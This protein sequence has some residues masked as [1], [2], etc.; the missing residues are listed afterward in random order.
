MTRETRDIVYRYGQEGL[1]E[2][3]RRMLE[4]AS[5]AQRAANEIGKG[6][7]D[8][9]ASMKVL[10]QSVREAQ[11]AV[12]DLAQRAGP[13]GAVLTRLGPAGLAAAASVAAMGG[14]LGKAVAEAINGERE[15]IKIEA[16]IRASGGA[17][18]KTAAEVDAL[19]KALAR[20]TMA[21]EEETKRA[22]TQ[23]LAFGRVAGE[24]FDRT[25]K[26][27]QDM[28]AA[29]FG[30]LSSNAVALGRALESPR[31]GLS[32]LSRLG[33][34]LTETQRDQI[35]VMAEMGREMEAQAMLLDIIA[36]KMGGTGAAERNTVAGAWHALS[37]ATEDYF[38]NLGEHLGVL[39]VLQA[40]LEGLT[41]AI[42]AQAAAMD[43][44]Y[45][46]LDDIDRRLNSVRM[47]GNTPQSL[48]A[49]RAEILDSLAA[50]EQ[51]RLDRS[52][53]T[54][55]TKLEEAYAGSIKATTTARLE[56]IAVIL[57]NNEK[58]L[59]AAEDR[60]QKIA[61]QR[62]EANRQLRLEHTRAYADLVD[63]IQD[64][65]YKA[66]DD[67]EGTIAK[68]LLSVGPAEQV[69]EWVAEHERA[70]DR[71]KSIYDE[72]SR[73][74]FDAYRDGWRDL[75]SGNIRSFED[76]A[77][78][79]KNIGIDLAANLIA[80]KTFGSVLGTIGGGAAGGA[81]GGG[82]LSGLLG[83]GAGAAGGAAAA[84]TAAG[85]AALYPSFVYGSAGAGG[86][87][88][89][90]LAA[91]L[92][93]PWTAA[94]VASIAAI[95]VLPGLIGPRP[96]DKI[97]GV[98]LDLIA[99]T[100]REGDLGP[101]KDSP[102]NRAQ[103]NALED[104]LVKLRETL[105]AFG[106]SPEARNVLIEV[107]SGNSLA[108][109]RAAV[110]GSG[111]Q[112]F[113]TAEEAFAFL[114]QRLID[115]LEVVPAR[116]QDVVDGFDPG[117]VEAFVS[118][119][120]RFADFETTLAGVRDEILQLTDPQAWDVKRIEDWYTKIREEALALG[121]DM[122]EIDRLRG[123]RLEMVSAQ[124]GAAAPQTP[125]AGPTAN[126]QQ[127]ITGLYDQR[128]A[129]LQDE[130]RALREAASSWERIGQA[131]RQASSSLLI[132]P[133]LSPLSLEAR[134]AESFNQL[135]DAFRRAQEGDT[136]AAAQLTDLARASLQASREFNRSSEDYYRDFER[137]QTILGAAQSLAA[138]HVTVAE[139]SLSVQ[140]QML[141]AL[142][143]GRGGVAGG[144]ASPG[145]T[146]A[147]V[148]AITEQFQAAW[149]RSG[150]SRSDFLQSAEGQSVWLPLRE[151]WISG[152]SD[153][154]QLYASL[155]AA[156]KQRGEGG[157]AASDA[158]LFEQ[159]ITGRLRELGL[160]VPEYALGGMVSRTGLAYVHE[161]EHVTPAHGMS[162]I[163]RTVSVLADRIDSLCRVVAASGQ[164]QIS[165][166]ATIA[167]SNERMAATE[168]MA[169]SRSHVG[170]RSKIER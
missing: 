55:L 33:V 94:A 150:L 148:A 144:G 155:E 160:D 7:R 112:S 126:W 134:R 83:A 4:M 100:R 13:L 146:Q 2:L 31:E 64:A 36:G 45:G 147:D 10:D 65:A 77:K 47:I 123:L 5:A 30:S 136:D 49:R 67:S 42:Q 162:G 103:S 8:G 113:Q 43:G 156:R 17:A 21:T 119:L 48:L 6:S 84:G 157:Y 139:M 166:L 20:N 117:N 34:Q 25:L 32:S 27:A 107:G 169:L 37:V 73:D 75:L 114:A 138:R 81:A 52:I 72:A 39:P 95:M 22:A 41:G 76:F 89:A 71:M 44:A 18:G 60:E 141:A 56:D 127:I 125:A 167:E 129:Q 164:E 78:R 133:S 158:T 26:L 145:Y 143:A 91:A 151:Q 51:E 61:A 63:R 120:Q 1:D 92:T 108:P 14:A 85:S 161:G 38:G 122:A 46:E 23:L 152:T 165:Q 35:V 24:T 101:N 68:M 106:L 28:A 116:L 163:E 80:E 50:A 53:K 16:V 105:L 102:E 93:N 140:E 54:D 154:A 153:S 132:D 130:A 115:S 86:G 9:S 135:E 66:L 70:A 58:A 170:T 104:A 82:W 118:D 142:Q 11:G 128:I 110:D 131:L 79:I 111:I 57:D 109:Y 15:L 40:G 59:K 62:E 90:G 168:Q 74:M 97:E 124:Y 137:V 88:G 3:Q 12:E 19:T 149:Q 121:Y 159:Q 87:A 29:G 69:Q 99:G 96:S 98:N